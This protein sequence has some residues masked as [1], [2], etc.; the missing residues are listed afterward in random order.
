MSGQRLLLTEAKAKCGLRQKGRVERDHSGCSCPS[1]R[2][3]RALRKVSRSPG[4]FPEERDSQRPATTRLPGEAATRAG[5]VKGGRGLVWGPAQGLSS[6]PCSSPASL[7]LFTCHSVLRAPCKTV[8]LL[9][10]LGCTSSRTLWACAHLGLGQELGSLLR[11]CRGHLSCAGL[12]LS[13]CGDVAGMALVVLN[14][15][16]RCPQ[17]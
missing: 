15:I 16:A 7:C 9:P 8:L 2:G 14:T 6:R 5:A 4:P 12:G 17:Q 13:V 1:R 3:S 11:S 10:P